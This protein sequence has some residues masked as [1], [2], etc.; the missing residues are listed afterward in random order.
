[1]GIL[2]GEL[3]GCM[4]AFQNRISGILTYL[5]SE[6]IWLPTFISVCV[7]SKF[8]RISE[9]WVNENAKYETS[10]LTIYGLPE[11][12]LELIYILQNLFS[13]WPL[14]LHQKSNFLLSSLTITRQI[15]FFFKVI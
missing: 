1:M 6:N 12:R 4:H 9:L 5:L 3:W 14:I 7:L 2:I 15:G 8:S 10:L 11:G 13:G